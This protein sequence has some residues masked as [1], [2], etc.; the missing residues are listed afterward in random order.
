M[1][2]MRPKAV[3][4]RFSSTTRGT[5]GHMAAGTSTKAAPS[6]TIM[7]MGFQ[8]VTPMS[9]WAGIRMSE[10]STIS[11]A[12]FPMRSTR[13][14]AKGAKIMDAAMTMLVTPGAVVNMCV[15]LKNTCDRK[16]PELGLTRGRPHLPWNMSVARAVKGKMAL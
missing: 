7:G 5:E 12:R 14:P 3:P 2:V 13:S 1:A 16:L 4:T 15:K 8:W 6:I 10:P 9:R 11:E